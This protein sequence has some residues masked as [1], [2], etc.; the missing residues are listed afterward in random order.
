MR[1]TGISSA[2]HQLKTGRNGW[3]TA[4]R[5]STLSP[6]PDLLFLP[7]AELRQPYANVTARGGVGETKHPRQP[8]SYLLPVFRVIRSY[9][10]PANGVENLMRRQLH[11]LRV[12]R[13]SLPRAL[14]VDKLTRGRSRPRSSGPLE[15]LI[16]GNNLRGADEFIV[17]VKLH[18][19]ALRR[20]LKPPSRSIRIVRSQ[21]DLAAYAARGKRIRLLGFNQPG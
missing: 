13:I 15:D 18:V 19:A 5:S 11:P 3:M 12:H 17:G 8:R 21:E 4:P 20:K 10:C 16:G 7:W 14:A 1:F 9:E 2:A 6:T